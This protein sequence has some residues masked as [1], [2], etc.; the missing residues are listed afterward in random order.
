MLIVLSS[1]VKVRYSPVTPK[2][3][4]VVIEVFVSTDFAK[5]NPDPKLLKSKLSTTVDPVF[6]RTL[7]PET[8][9]VI[10][11]IENCVSTLFDCVVK[12]RPS[13][14]W[15]NDLKLPPVCPVG[16]VAEFPIG[17]SGP[18]NPIGPVGPVGPVP[19]L[20]NFE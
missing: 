1:S 6:P 20:T 4:R 10:A 11:V 14:F 17:P 9:P 8:P 3:R 16:P 2:L 5:V 13:L 18:V 19:V 12:V 15:L 7:S